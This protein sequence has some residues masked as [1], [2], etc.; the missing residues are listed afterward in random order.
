MK[1]KYRACQNTGT[2]LAQSAGQLKEGD[3][4]AEADRTFYP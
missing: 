2:V 1:F 3:G 4:Q